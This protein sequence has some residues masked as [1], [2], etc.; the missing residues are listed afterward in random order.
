VV[1]VGAN[2][3]LATADA[4]GLDALCDETLL[5]FPREMAPGYH[6]AMLDTLRQA[7]VEPRV[8]IAPDTGHA[9]LTLSMLEA[10]AAVALAPIGIATHWARTAAGRLA[11]VPVA[12]DAPL[13]LHVFWNPAACGTAVEQFVELA[14][15]LGREGALTPVAART[16][17][18]SM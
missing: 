8:A 7:G 10:G 6:D 14:Q 16:D 4:L 18:A 13:P 9:P 1:V 2:H 17:K 3:E 11:L 12:D 5:T 15:S